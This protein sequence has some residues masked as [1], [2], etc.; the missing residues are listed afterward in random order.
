MCPVSNLHNV[1]L[2]TFNV[3]NMAATYGFTLFSR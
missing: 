1:P 2:K 3:D